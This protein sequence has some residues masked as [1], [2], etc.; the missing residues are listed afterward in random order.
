MLHSEENPDYRTVHLLW[1][2]RISTRKLTTPICSINFY[3]WWKYNN[4]IFRCHNLCERAFI[5]LQIAYFTF[6]LSP[7]FMAAC[8]FCQH[9]DDKFLT[10]CESCLSLLF[11]II[12]DSIWTLK[13]DFR[14]S[15]P[16]G[17]SDMPVIESPMHYVRPE[18]HHTT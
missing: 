9:K 4:V 3:F 14:E 13:Y 16:Q 8:T 18:R 2:G 1:M 17:L 5:S 6:Q 7:T 15:N 11:H 12:N 10:K